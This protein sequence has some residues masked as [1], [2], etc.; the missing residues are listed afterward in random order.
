MPIETKTTADFEKI[1][2][3]LTALKKEVNKTE[4]SNKVAKELVKEIKRRAPKDTGAY[5]RQWAIRHRK[6]N[7]PYKTV[8]RISP[9]NRKLP[10]PYNYDNIRYDQ[11]FKWLEFEGTQSHIITPRKAS[12]L[13]FEYPKGSGQ[14]IFRH[15]VRHPGT[16]PTPH[17]RPAMRDILPHSM[18]RKFL[19]MKQRFVWLKR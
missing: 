12:I 10:G 19:D 16:K 18:Q 8:I 14:I 6:R 7:T 5:A 15:R 2:N 9:G 11:L 13:R 3:E 4:W 1:R 17:V